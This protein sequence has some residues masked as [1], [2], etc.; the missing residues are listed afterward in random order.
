ML[1]TVLQFYGAISSKVPRTQTVMTMA[2]LFLA[3]REV[4]Y[5]HLISILESGVGNVAPSKNMELYV[6]KRKV[7]F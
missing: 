5:Q 7:S 3:K 1:V 2:A 4:G 6:T